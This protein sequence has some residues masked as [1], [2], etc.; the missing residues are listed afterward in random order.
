MAKAQP[1]AY[2]RPLSFDWLTPLYD[3]TIALLLPE[4]ALKRQLIEQANAGPRAC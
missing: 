2:L 4:A 3:R 1:K